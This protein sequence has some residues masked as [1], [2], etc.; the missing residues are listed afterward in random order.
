MDFILGRLTLLE[1]SMKKLIAV[2]AVLLLG[3]CAGIGG[4]PT[5]GIG[6]LDGGNTGYVRF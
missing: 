1:E 2:I 3:A 5:S 4:G 6:M